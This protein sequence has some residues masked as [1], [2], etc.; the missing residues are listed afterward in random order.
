[1]SQTIEKTPP[2][3]PAVP[4]LSFIPF[5]FPHV[6]NVSCA[7]QMRTTHGMTASALATEPL[8]H[9]NISLDITT[10]CQT[11]TQD[12]IANRLNI[13]PTLGVTDWAELHQVHG[14]LIHFDPEPQSPHTPSVVQGD[15]FATTRPRRALMIKTA[16]CQPVLI[17]HKS[18]AHVAA[19]HI[20][21]RGNRIHFLHSGIAA[22]CA[23]YR[24][25][26]RDL[27]AVRGPSL[28]PSAAQ[29][30]NFDAEWG[31]DF[32][33]Y[34]NSDLQTMNLWRLTHDQLC[35]AGLLPHNIFSLDLCT[36]SL[37]RAFFSYR[38]ERVTGRQASFIWIDG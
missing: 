15:A 32:V 21:W 29:F 7:F 33:P 38:R 19:F 36:L 5:Q 6:P 10:A 35:A 3:P 31:P 34:F 13:S 18:G 37:A 4:P 2:S 28:G 9:G 26:P 25:A 12:A 8:A 27:M 22:F 30:T 11:L 16:D 14:D 23:R 20:G 17:A 1:M 24:L